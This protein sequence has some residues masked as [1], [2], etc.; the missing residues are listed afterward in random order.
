VDSLKSL[1]QTCGGNGNVVFAG[2]IDGERRSSVLRQASLLALTSYQEN[3]GLCAVEALACS[4]PVL[5]SPE[6]NLAYE[7]ESVGAG[8]VT[9][10]EVGA[11]ERTL[12]ETLSDEKELLRRG[13]IGKDFVRRRF[14]WDAV[15]EELADFY[16]SITE[17]GRS[18]GEHLNA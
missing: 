15:A 7:V 11:L 1:A 5:L 14:T 9:P 2:W 4:V 12:A 6:V 8:W 10:L 16:V 13:A 17:Q 18:K 3:F